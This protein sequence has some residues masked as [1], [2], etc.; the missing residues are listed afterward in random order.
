MVERSGPIRAH[1]KELYGVAEG[2]SAYQRLLAIMGRYRPLLHDVHPGPL[3]QQ[4]AI[5][6]TYADQLRAPGIPSL[7][8]LAHFCERQLAGLVSGVHILPFYPSS[9]DD[10]FSVL[11]Y[12]AVDPGLGSW[13]DIERLGRNFRLMFDAVINHASAGSPWFQALLRD[14][15]PYRD[16]FTTVT[17]TPDLSAVARPRALPLLTRFDTVSGPRQVWTTFSAD[18]V[19]LN[20]QNPDLLV[21]IVDTLLFYVSQGAELIRLDAIAYLWKEI[22][23]SC[24][25]LPQTHRVIQLF[26]AILDELSPGVKLVTETNVPHADN[27]SYFGDGKNEAQLVYNFALP[28]LVLHTLHTG[29]AQALS[30]WAASLSLPGNR[31]TFFNFLASHD[32]IGLNPVRG[33]LVEAEI[34]SLVERVQQQG[35]LVSYKHDPDGRQSPYELNVN[36]FDAL[37]D[38]ADPQPERHIERFLAAHAIL[39]SLVGLPAI[40]FHSLFGSVGWPQGVSFTGMNRSINRQKFV[41]DAFERELADPASRRHKVFTRLSRLLRARA[42][43]PAFSPYGKQEVLDEGRGVFALVRGESASG[44]V[45]CLQNV[46]G[47]TQLLSRGAGTVFSRR[48]SSLVDLVGGQTLDARLDLELS[49]YQTLW[50]HP[51]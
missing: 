2:K 47:E 21:E 20:Y 39:L 23:T 30:A 13:D 44:R 50:L 42:S 35:G 22:G 36:Y 3:T 8:T 51:S 33:I 11:D 25:H 38:P 4:D 41:V 9:S 34:K 5:L 26:R 31:A 14:E 18:Q 37:A 46:T 12:R 45:L 40:Y 43:H 29:S 1:L 6:I 32:G 16:F 28:P 49:P 27:I 7:Q 17:G 48:P 19:D 24:I 10:G 15:P